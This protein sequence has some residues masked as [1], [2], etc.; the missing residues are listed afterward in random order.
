MGCFESPYSTVS[1]SLEHQLPLKFS[2]DQNYPNPFN[3]STT[4]RYELPHQ[5]DV[6]IIV[7]DVLGQIVATLV[8]ENQ[9]AGYGSV[10]WDGK[11]KLGHQV[12]TGMFLY[13]IH[14]G[15]FTQTRKMLLLK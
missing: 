9:A 15:E 6:Q 4:I 11:D 10:Q 7:Y 1:I 2:L 12:S 5:S 14:A 13:V 3:P 8:S